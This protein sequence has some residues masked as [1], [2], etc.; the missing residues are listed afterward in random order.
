MPHPVHTS[1]TVAARLASGARSIPSRA[2]LV[3]LTSTPFLYDRSDVVKRWY[4][5][6]APGEDGPLAVDWNTAAADVRSGDVP[7][8]DGERAVVL[9]AASIAGVGTVNLATVFRHLDRDN[10]AA[11]LSAF[12]ALAGDGAPVGLNLTHYGLHG[13]ADR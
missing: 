11:L 5:P 10:A 12:A 6:A 3:V 7:V 8:S 2:A 9:L 4:Y 1:P 13:Q